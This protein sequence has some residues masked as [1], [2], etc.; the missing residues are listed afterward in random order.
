MA[1]Y[2]DNPFEWDRLASLC[3]TSDVAGVPTVVGYDTEFDGV[4]I[5][6]ESTVGRAKIHVFSLA[7]IEPGATESAL[8]FR[9]PTGY[10][11]PERALRHPSIKEML[12]DKNV[13]KPIHNQ[14]VDSHATYNSGVVLRGGIN[15]LDMARFLYPW[16]AQ[17]V[18]GNYDLDSICKWRIGQGK[19][20]DFD[21]LLGY[22]SHETYT[23]ERT[24]K[25]CAC[26]EVG[27]RKKKA[28]HDVKS[29]VQRVVELSRV[30]RRILA[31]EQLVPGHRLWERYIAY[32]ASDA[33]L[34]LILYQCML[35]D[36]QKG[37]PYPWST[38]VF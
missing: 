34:A 27:C 26:G 21:D 18:R 23:M 10:V 28:P 30:V 1:T 20:D 17:L 2:L 25:L 19:T 35:L 32:A 9:H 11:L 6:S 3:Y 12:E 24:V 8:G 38:G 5:N 36:G 15:T 31:L 33:T 29:D 14:P 7:V 4:D 13:L 16:R 37:R 22:D